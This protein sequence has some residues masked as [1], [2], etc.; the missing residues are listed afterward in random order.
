MKKLLIGADT[1]TK[2]GPPI[3]FQFYSQQKPSLNGVIFLN[4][5]KPSQVLFNW[6]DEL[7]ETDTETIIYGHNLKFD[8]LSFL[9]DRAKILNSENFCETINGWTIKGV[10]AGL[11]FANLK[12]GRKRVMFRDTWAYYHASLAELEKTFKL[13]LPKLEAPAGLGERDFSPTDKAFCAYA[14][15]DAEIAYHIGEIIESWH[16]EYDLPQ[17]HSIADMSAKIFKSKFVAKPLVYPGAT[18]THCA[19]QAYHGGK[20]LLSAKPGSYEKVY[21]LDIN[22]A[23]PH[24]MTTLPS[25]ANREGFKRVE[26]AQTLS[27]G[28]VHGV[29]KVFGWLN[30]CKYPIFYRQGAGMLAMPG[31]LFD[32]EGRSRVKQWLGGENYPYDRQRIEGLWVTGWELLEAI[33]SREFAC[34]KFFGYCYQD[35][36]D[37]LK[38]PYKPFKHFAQHFFNLKN[39]EADP[40]RRL[41]YK[42][43]L[44]SLSGKLAETR[45]GPEDKMFWDALNSEMVVEE[46]RVA[47]SMFY[48]L[49]AALITGHTRARIHQLEHKYQSLHTSTDGILTQTK[50]DPADIGD[51]LGEL[52]LEGCGT[53]HLVRNKLYVLIDERGNI[54]KETR[55]GFRGKL[56]ALLELVGLDRREYEYLHCNQLAESVRRGLTPNKFETYEARVKL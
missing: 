13:N 56:Q 47:G 48:S 41:T 22:S 38:L 4:N 37:Y 39:C 33:Y 5:R 20:N 25:F 42:L 34:E 32:V 9:Y 24:A 23:Y 49:A 36:D 53:L 52:K 28:C 46:N 17:T 35:S 19:F 11:V 40:V 55:H 45:R 7:P 44:N 26:G 14:L 30:R 29:Y 54:I 51:G 15:R 2:Q 6:L 43:V 50:P 21:S 31:D 27:I 8:L 1:E 18:I 10:Y 16:S 3:T 12:K